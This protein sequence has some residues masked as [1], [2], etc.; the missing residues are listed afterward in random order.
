MD[1]TEVLVFGPLKSSTLFAVGGR[2]IRKNVSAEL[3][4]VKFLLKKIRK[5]VLSAELEEVLEL[6]PFHVLA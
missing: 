6:L 3:E 2:K 4:E 5:N 1:A